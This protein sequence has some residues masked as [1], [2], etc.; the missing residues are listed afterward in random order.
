[1]RRFNSQ[2]DGQLVLDALMRNSGMTWNLLCRE[3]GFEPWTDVLDPRPM[4]L[5]N[6][7]WALSRAGLVAVDGVPDEKTAEFIQE[8]LQGN[9]SERKLRASAMWVGIQRVL[10]F[11][12]GGGMP[13]WPLFGSPKETDRNVEIFVVMPFATEFQPVY[14]DHIRKTAIA[15]G[16]SVARADD[17][18]TNDHIMSDVWAAICS[19]K[20]VVSDCTGRNPNVFYETGIAHT[21]GTP[22]ILITQRPEDIPADLRHIK[23]ITYEYTPQGMTT[24]EASLQNTISTV[25]ECAE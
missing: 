15:L 13:V 14:Q 8:A 21:V 22:V 6:C 17:L 25:L 3:L 5:Y 7:L 16:Y 24:F 9:R 19:A 10:G 23:Y 12:G 20:I 1:M 11:G 2:Y 18:F 4:R